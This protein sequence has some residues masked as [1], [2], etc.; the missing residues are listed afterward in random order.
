MSALWGPGLWA[1][2]FVVVYALQGTG[3]ALGW[4][5][6]LHRGGLALVWVLALAGG[7]WLVWRAPKGQDTRAR[8]DRAGAL[9]RADLYRIYPLSAGAA[10]ALCGGAGLTSAALQGTFLPAGP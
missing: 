1:L 9:D 3:C 4:P 10:A 2:A 5:A 6:G 8:I 7:A